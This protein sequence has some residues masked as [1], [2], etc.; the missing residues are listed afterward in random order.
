[1]ENLQEGTD[2]HEKKGMKPR[3]F[4][5][6]Y[7]LSE[8]SVYRACREGS[9]PTIRVGNRFVILWKQWEMRANA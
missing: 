8:N 5:K 4:A 1:M 9:I 3:E 2:K 6:K 7:G